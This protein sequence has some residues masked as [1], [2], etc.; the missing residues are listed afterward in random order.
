[1]SGP[2]S[3]EA[4]GTLLLRLH[5]QPGAKRTGWAGLHGEAIKVRL[6]AP[7]VEGQANEALLRFLA[8][9]FAVP[10]R[11]VSLRSG[12]GARQKWVAVAGSAIDIQII[13]EEIR[14]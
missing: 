5:V 6:A 2:W 14:K 13:M 3:R 12:A 4:D 1:M 7:P 11:Q 10:L 8:D 9:A